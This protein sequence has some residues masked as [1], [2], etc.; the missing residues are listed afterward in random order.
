MGVREQA[1]Y[2]T[3][4]GDTALSQPADFRKLVSGYQDSTFFRCGK[5]L[6]KENCPYRLLSQV[7]SEGNPA[8]EDGRFGCGLR[9][10][11]FEKTLA[12]IDLSNPLESYVAALVENVTDFKLEKIRCQGGLSKRAIALRKIIMDDWARLI[13]F[14]EKSKEGKKFNFLWQ[15]IS[16]KKGVTKADLEDVLE[17]VPAREVESDEGVD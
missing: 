16:A 7:D 8:F 9:R 4:L 11:I 13:D 1:A 14:S 3:G 12:S 5:C 10:E 2:L 6:V 15:S 17:P